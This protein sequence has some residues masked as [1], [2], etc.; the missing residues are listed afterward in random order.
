MGHTVSLYVN[1][2]LRHQIVEDIRQNHRAMKYRLHNP[3]L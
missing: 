2:V 1:M 3:K